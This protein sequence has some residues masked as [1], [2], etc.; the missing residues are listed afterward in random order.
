VRELSW[1][2]TGRFLATGGGPTVCVWD[3]AGKGPEGSTPKMMPGNAGTLT[4]VAWQR[5]GFLVAAGDEAGRVC[6]FQPANRTPLVGGATFS[7]ADLSVL[8]WSPDDK[9]L[10]VGS[11]SGK[12]GMFTLV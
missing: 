11:G 4:G 6:L 9:K 7:G 8:A 3:C 1:D 5:R 10:A 2:F 12:L